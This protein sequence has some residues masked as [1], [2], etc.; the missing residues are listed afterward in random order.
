MPRHDTFESGRM[1]S[2]DNLARRPGEL[3]RQS[4]CLIE[5]NTLHE[6]GASL[7]QSQAGQSAPVQMEQ[8]KNVIH[9]RVLP[10]VTP[11]LQGVKRRA[12]VRIESHDFLIENQLMWG[13]PGA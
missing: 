5:N 2:L 4:Q 1:N 9:D 8:I 11:S 13:E 6:L 3:L 10:V 7:S 12:S